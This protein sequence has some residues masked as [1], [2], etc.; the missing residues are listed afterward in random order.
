RQNGLVDE[1]GGLD[2]ALAYAAKAAKLDSWHP[3]Y[4][5]QRDEQWASILQRLS[6]GDDDSA[7][8]AEVGDFAGAVT[9]SQMGL[10]G[11]ALAGAERLIGTRGVQA[12]C[13]ECP[14][15]AGGKMPPKADLSLL[16]RVAK[17]LGLS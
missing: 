2:Q 6:G 11:K 16:A 7:P 13:L 8:P 10:I 12:Y 14:A 17:L 15:S 9:E 1:F 4:L 3:E 5:G